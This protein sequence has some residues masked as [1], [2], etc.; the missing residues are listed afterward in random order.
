MPYIKT[1]ARKDLLEGIRSPRNAGELNFMTTELI[2]DYLMENGLCYQSFNDI[3]G[4]L[5]G[6]KLEMYRRL[7]AGYEDQKIQENGEVYVDQLLRKS[8]G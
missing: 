6:A 8:N 1:D 3:V 2:N 7:T 4:A 5:E